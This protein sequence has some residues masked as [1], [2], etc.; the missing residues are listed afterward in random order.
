MKDA[1]MSWQQIFRAATPAERYEILL[2]MMLRVESFKI[3]LIPRQSERSRFMANSLV[4]QGL[5]LLLGLWLGTS[6]G[7][8]MILAVNISLAGAIALQARRH[9]ATIRESE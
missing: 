4:I 3:R 5:S 6:A 7:L 2:F 8:M 1:P 9:N